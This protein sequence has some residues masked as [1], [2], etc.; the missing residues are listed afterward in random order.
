MEQDYM[1][2]G[3]VPLFI[4]YILYILSNFFLCVLAVLVYEYT[5]FTSPIKPKKARDKSPAVISPI[6][7]P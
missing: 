4:L 7:I 3:S 6:A 1:L 2:G 5:Y